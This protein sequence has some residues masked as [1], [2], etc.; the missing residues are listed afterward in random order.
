MEL[1][2]ITEGLRPAVRFNQDDRRNWKVRDLAVVIKQLT[3]MEGKN[4]QQKGILQKQ[5]RGKD[6]QG[7]RTKKHG[8]ATK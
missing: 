8:D 1:L 3:L 5:D 2:Y 7:M 4:K 6:G